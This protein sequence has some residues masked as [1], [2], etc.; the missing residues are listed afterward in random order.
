MLRQQ[1]FGG[2]NEWIENSALKWS[3][4]V[5]VVDDCLG[6][7]R[8]VLGAEG[9]K[10]QGKHGSGPWV[11]KGTIEIPIGSWKIEHIDALLKSKLKSQD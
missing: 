10:A 6:E 8:I 4:E 1:S 9:S 11:G 3:A 7:P 2:V 5:E